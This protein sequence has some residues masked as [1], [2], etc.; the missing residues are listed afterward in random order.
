MNYYL[1]PSGMASHIIDFKS[2]GATKNWNGHWTFSDF[3]WKIIKGRKK[4]YINRYPYSK[5]IE[6]H[7]KYNFK[8][9]NINLYKKDSFLKR[10]I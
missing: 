8:V 5:H 4:F 1:K 6:M 3:E 10:N 9:I 7:K 2:H